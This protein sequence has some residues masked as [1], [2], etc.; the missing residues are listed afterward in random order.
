M[1]IAQK[2]PW[3]FVLLLAIAWELG[4]RIGAFLATILFMVVL[5]REE[6]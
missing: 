4:D 3:I 2:D 1:T 5:L 6:K